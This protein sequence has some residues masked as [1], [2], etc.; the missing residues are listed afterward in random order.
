MSK[1]LPKKGYKH[2]GIL[3]NTCIIF[4]ARFYLGVLDLS[5]QEKIGIQKAK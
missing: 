2:I 5:L 3:V 4:K 1:I